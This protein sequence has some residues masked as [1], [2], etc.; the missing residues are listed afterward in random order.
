MQYLS[1]YVCGKNCQRYAPYT[2]GFSEE[3]CDQV[4]GTWCRRPCTTLKQCI[5]KKPARDKCRLAAKYEITE[6]NFTR[7][8]DFGECDNVGEQI[9]LIVSCEDEKGNECKLPPPPPESRR[10]RLLEYSGPQYNSSTEAGMKQKLK[11]NT[12]SGVGNATLPGSG[13][14]TPDPICEDKKLTFT[15]TVKYKAKG[16]SNGKKDIIHFV[17][18]QDGAQEDLF[19]ALGNTTSL[20][21]GES[22]LVISSTKTVK[23]CS[24]RGTYKSLLAMDLQTANFNE[25]FALFSEGMVI[26]DDSDESQCGEVRQNLGFNADYIGEHVPFGGIILTCILM[27]LSRI[28]PLKLLFLSL[29]LLHRRQ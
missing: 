2:L 13:N 14:D 18:G 25:G 7:R 9:I 17:E 21:F 11:N 10:R 1:Q 22:P 19:S 12:D 24:D 29:S 8:P 4:G 23:L 20:V 16:T 6:S 3:A 15:Y 28:S 5:E 27:Q 26:T